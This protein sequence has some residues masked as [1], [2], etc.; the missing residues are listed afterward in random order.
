MFEPG[1]YSVD[2]IEGDVAVLVGADGTTYDVMLCDLPDGVEERTVLQY[3]NGAFRP[4]T[5]A[6][7]QQEDRIKAL[8]DRLR[9]RK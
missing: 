3:E 5:A 1:V 8:Q 6:Q 9:K 2:R 7:R 4:D